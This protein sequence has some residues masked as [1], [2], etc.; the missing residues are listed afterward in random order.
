M[1]PAP[2]SQKLTQSRRRKPTLAQKFSSILILTTGLAIMLTTAVFTINGA[3]KIYRD[4]QNQ[5]LSLGL[6]ISQNTQAAL[7]F[8][9]R[10]SAE[11]TLSALQAKPEINAAYIYDT[12]DALFASYTSPSL[13]DHDPLVAQIKPVL[14]ALFPV[15]LQLEQPIT[16]DNEAIGRIILHADIYHTWMQLGANLVTNILLSLASMVL[17][18]W[19]GLRLSK[20]ITHPI[21]ELARA[22]DQV[23][24]DQDYT[25]RVT[26]SNFEE[27]GALIGNFN[28][29]L[30]EIRL[31]DNQLHRHQVHL[32]RKVKERTTE[33]RRAK[34][35]AEAAN[36]A[37]SDF[38][39]NMSHEIRT[40][41][42]AVLG[43]GYL[44]AKTE[45]T[46]KQRDYY[47]AI[48]SSSENLLGIINDILDFSKIE[49][50]KLDMEVADFNLSAVLTHLSNLFSTK[51]EEKNV[52]FMISCMPSIPDALI[53]DSLRLGQ[54]LINLTSNALKFTD[55]GEVVVAVEVLEESTAETVLR[56]SVRDTGIGMTQEQI[57]A[58][59][60]PFSQ[61]DC[62]TTRRFGGTGLGLAISKRLVEL[63]NGQ[64]GVTSTMGLGSE[65]FFTARFGKNSIANP[66]TLISNT[67]IHQQRILVVDNNATAREILRSMLTD[68]NLNVV[69][70]ASGE[71]AIKELERA[72]RNETQFYDLVLMDWQMPF[73]DGI[74]AIHRIR[75]NHSLPRT[76]TL[77]MVTAF[78]SEELLNRIDRQ[79]LDGLLF[80]PFTHSVLFDAIMNALD[81][82]KSS[83]VPLP[84]QDSN[85][86]EPKLQGHILL[87]E[88]NMI[89]Q[90]IA[91][92]ILENTGLNVTIAGNG[93]EAIEKVTETTYDLVLMDIQ[94]PLMDGY[95]ATETIRR[96]FSLQELPIIAMTANAMSGDRE[97]CLSAGM[98]DHIAK[99]FNRVTLYRI[100]GQ[101]LA[102]AN[103]NAV[104][105]GTDDNSIKP[106]LTAQNSPALLPDSI[107]GINLVAGLARLQQNHTL[108]RKLLLEFHR[109]HH[110]TVA[111]IQ[112]AMADGNIEN[113]KRMTH[114]VKGVAGNLEMV[115]L[116][117]ATRNLDESLKRGE[118]KL[119]L[120]QTFQ[121]RF[122]EVMNALAELPKQQLPDNK[123]TFKF[124]AEALFPLLLTLTNHLNEGNPRA[125]DVL[126]EC[127]KYLGEMIPEHLEKL[128]AQIDAY[129]FEEASYTLTQIK[130]TLKTTLINF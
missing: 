86:Q 8:G 32:E 3:I 130:D 63:M 59:F 48:K 82:T 25:I 61:A 128:G 24:R 80:K 126:I 51:A 31:R 64:I 84:D 40:P 100:L 88:D 26:H 76:P 50:G 5:L 74:E 124:N 116:F 62:S 93:L 16:R 13:H 2:D 113:A 7:L 30:E 43:M 4:T 18:V 1:I 66:R 55:S 54:V 127:K 90:Q 17:A 125:A 112:A 81:K 119:D 10:N 23:T 6:V 108:Y 35:V 109:D 71:E 36:R 53:G 21:M 15:H 42:N 38:L 107:A 20:T 77:I 96:R 65:F 14:L 92:Q 106:E 129:N 72:A 105:P 57:D 9:D 121:E 83:N 89:N 70:L 103:E 41:M 58:L 46:K 117:N 22:A 122:D 75:A 67:S 85:Q 28:F 111:H 87:V 45:L 60:Q 19:L 120:L 95:E 56:F 123:S 69:T 115:D 29:M 79:E 68:F 47:N 39:A 91:Q 49:A 52:E 73:M 27:I 34:E 37:K 110:H 12:K 33:L 102:T 114:A 101:W 99:P 118:I 98:N 94:M 104:K 78:G 97:R 11:T 44:L